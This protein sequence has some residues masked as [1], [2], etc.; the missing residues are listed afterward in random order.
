M[1][2]ISEKPSGARTKIE[3]LETYTDDVDFAVVLLTPDDVDKPKDKFG[4][5]NFRASQDV[6]LQLGVLIGK[7]GR[8]QICLLCKGKLELPSYVDGINPV[9]LDANG[10]WILRLIREMKDAGL[11]INIGKV[12]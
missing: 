3:Q 6:I 2:I 10:G 7:Y 12:I 1:I 4:E 11:P 8:D 9:L 5:P